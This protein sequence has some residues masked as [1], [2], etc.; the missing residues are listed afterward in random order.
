MASGAA[1]MTQATPTLDLMAESDILSIN[2][3]EAESA[4]IISIFINI[5]IAIAS[6][7][8]VNILGGLFVSSG[9]SSMDREMDSDTRSFNVVFRVVAPVI[10][11]CPMACLASSLFVDYLAST[12]W[13]SLV[14]YWLL[15][16]VITILLNPASLDSI[17][18]LVRAVVSCLLGAYFSIFLVS[19]GFESLIP[20]R[21]DVVF[22]FWLIIGM[23]CI[24][25]IVG[26][27]RKRTCEDLEKYYYEVERCAEALLPKRYQ[28]DIAL[29]ILFYTV[30]MIEA[31]YRGKWFRRLERLAAYLGIA[32][33]TGI[34][35]VVSSIPLSDEESVVQSFPIIEIIWDEYLSKSEA[36]RLSAG[37]SIT[38]NDSYEYLTSS[39]LD[40]MSLDANA[41]YA[42]YN[43]SDQVNARKF[44]SVARRKVLQRDYLRPGRDHKTKVVYHRPIAELQ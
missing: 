6:T 30:G 17:G 19:S 37:Y 11:W 35:Q 44:M 28:E 31:H 29:K 39:M 9:Y 4:M 26:I 8:V 16:F 12:A 5:G 36:I 3:L 42:R 7:L 27:G 1:I 22:Q 38:G 21:G 18:I 40:E 13:I 32:K 2:Q 41:L 14:F 25:L 10:V 23:A 33:S 34:M 43:G 15:R 20:D 24:S